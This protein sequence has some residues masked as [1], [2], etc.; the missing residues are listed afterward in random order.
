MSDFAHD[1][2]DFSRAKRLPLDPQSI[3]RVCK[4]LVV[5]Q[6]HHELHASVNAR[7]DSTTKQDAAFL[8]HH[9]ATNLAM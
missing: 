5:L 4:N 9:C 6:A 3:K 2:H 8:K 1:C 7:D